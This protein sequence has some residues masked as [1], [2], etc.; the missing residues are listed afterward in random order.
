L[1]NEHICQERIVLKLSFQTEVRNPNEKAYF[2]YFLQGTVARDM[3]QKEIVN[4]VIRQ[5]H[6]FQLKSDGLQGA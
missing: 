6:R 5:R 1:Q 3:G 2:L 4:S